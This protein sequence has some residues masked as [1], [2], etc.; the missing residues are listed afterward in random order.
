[1][2]VLKEITKR[3]IR[4]A[5]W[6]LHRF[7]PS[8]SAE[9]QLNRC[10]ASLDIDTVFDVGANAGQFGAGIRSAGFGGEIISFEP[11]SQARQSLLKAAGQDSKWIVHPQAAIGDENGEIEINISGNSVSSSALT[12]LDS[13]SSAAANSAYVG[14]ER[15]P[16]HRLDSVADQYLSD[17]S[18]LLVKIDTQGYETQVINGG[19][20]TIGKARGVLCEMSMVPL[21]EGQVLWEELVEQFK[22]IDFVLWALFKGFTDP[23]TGQTLQADGLFVKRSLIE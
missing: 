19:E 11:L 13:H 8:A 15:V 3:I 10:L 20:M 4:A 16:I 5:G 9:A 2:I 7:V 17:D 14:K 1:M 18:K 22:S 12:M 21:Y 23:R 6:D